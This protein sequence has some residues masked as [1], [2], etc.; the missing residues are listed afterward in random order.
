MEKII[1]KNINL[2]KLMIKLKKNKKNNNMNQLKCCLCN[3]NLDNKNNPFPL[4]E[5]KNVYCCNNC[6]INKVIPY[7]YLLNKFEKNKTKYKTLLSF[8]NS[9]P[10]KNI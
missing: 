1:D 4:V 5:I 6:D 10:E 8:L 7:R 9:E 2:I 3:K